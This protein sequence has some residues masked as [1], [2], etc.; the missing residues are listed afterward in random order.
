[1]ANTVNLITKANTRVMSQGPVYQIRASFDTIGELTIVTPGGTINDLDAV[2]VETG[3]DEDSW[4]IVGIDG[5]DTTGA[6][7]TFKSA[8]TA[9]HTIELG[10]G[11]GLGLPVNE[12][13]YWLCGRPGEALKIATSATAPSSLILHIVLAERLGR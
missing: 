9:I 5:V 4:W 2:A 1:M 8:D 10:A 11:Q 7:L 3:R 12:H 13:T 6:T